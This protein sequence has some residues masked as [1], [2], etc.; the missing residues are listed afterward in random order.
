[1]TICQRSAACHG[2]H[3][4]PSLSGGE[5]GGEDCLGMA[6]RSRVGVTSQGFGSWR[7]VRWP[8]CGSFSVTLSTSCGVRVFGFLVLC[9]ASLHC[10][11]HARGEH[12]SVRHE[13]CRR[14]HPNDSS[15][16][17]ST[18]ASGCDVDN[19]TGSGPDRQRKALEAICAY[20]R[21]HGLPP[22]RGE[23]FEVLGLTSVVRGRLPD[24]ATGQSLDRIQT[25]R[26][27]RGPAARRSGRGAAAQ[28]PRGGDRE[29]A[30]EERILAK[31]RMP[32][33]GRV[34]RRAPGS[35]MQWWEGP[36]WG[37]TEC[38]RRR[39]VAMVGASNR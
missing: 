21:R 23:L 19:G 6:P 7:N 18:P 16:Q 28:R 20:L 17:Y 9:Q 15:A 31:S 26:E 8:A 33:S 4:C 5:I 11:V 10:A 25:R 14:R 13:E 22:L 29:M 36:S 39:D 24:R 1:M 12:H 3:R 37:G 38:E 32:A 34:W 35:R 30:V 27:A 2:G